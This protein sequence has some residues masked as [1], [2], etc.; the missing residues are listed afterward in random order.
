MRDKD[1]GVGRGVTAV[2]GLVEDERKR[3]D[4]KE[5]VNCVLDRDMGR[6]S[7]EEIIG[8]NAFRKKCSLCDGCNYME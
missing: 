1:E 6:D 7:L 2:Q 8:M 5:A 3:D 4:D